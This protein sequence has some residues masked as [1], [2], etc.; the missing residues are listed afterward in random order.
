MLWRF[1]RWSM[2][3]AVLWHACCAPFVDQQI[4]MESHG[5]VWIDTNETSVWHGDNVRNQHTLILVAIPVLL[6]LSCQEQISVHYGNRVA[7]VKDSAFERGWLPSQIPSDAVNIYE[8]HD[9][10]TNRVWI[11]FDVPTSTRAQLL[12]SLQ[13][14]QDDRIGQLRFPTPRRANWWDLGIV[15]ARSNGV[16]EVKPPIYS[17]DWHQ[18]NSG[19]VFID[20]SKGRIYYWTE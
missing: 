6:L 16:N 10:D 4:Q 7:A 11:R 5:P 13:Q 2:R 3:W 18:P 14:I 8:Q 1:R 20:Q 15:R 9:I 12:R 19:F 17:A